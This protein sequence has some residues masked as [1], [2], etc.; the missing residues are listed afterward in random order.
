MNPHL[1]D[2]IYSSSTGTRPIYGFWWNPVRMQARDLYR[3]AS[4]QT[5]AES[6]AHSKRT[7]GISG[8]NLKK[9]GIRTHT[10]NRTPLMEA[11]AKAV[12]AGIPASTIA[13][14]T[15]PASSVVFPES[16]KA[17]D[18]LVTSGVTTV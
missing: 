7:N 6:I 12:V 5:L 9:D 18:E 4:I 11:D 17:Q 13:E 14:W 8:N 1:N 3:P 10:D 15:K 16:K 2:M